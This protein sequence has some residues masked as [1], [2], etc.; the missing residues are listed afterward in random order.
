M[1]IIAVPKNEAKST[2][3]ESELLARLF[4]MNYAS[5]A[6][7]LSSKACFDAAPTI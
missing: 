1:A 3:T 4:A 6:L 5:N 2:V 7:S